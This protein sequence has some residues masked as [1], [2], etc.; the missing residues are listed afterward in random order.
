[1]NWSKRPYGIAV[2]KDQTIYIAVNEDNRIY[3]WKKNAI[4]SQVVAGQYDKTDG[5]DALDNPVNVIVDHQNDVLI[6]ADRGNSRVM[7]WPRSNGQC[8]EQIVSDIR[9]WGLAMGKNGELYVLDSETGVVGRWKIGEKDGTLVV[10]GNGSGDFL[11]QFYEPRHIFVDDNESVYVSDSGNH[12]VMKWMKDAREGVIVAGGH[13]EGDS[14]TQLSFPSG[15]F[16]DQLE[17]VYI[18]DS[19]NNRI[20]RWL[21]GSKEG[22]VVVGGND[23]GDQPDQL[24]DPVDLVFDEENNLYVSDHGNRRVQKFSVVGSK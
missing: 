15:I 4:T 24:D 12:R 18:A 3:Q 5:N 21:K 6:I 17:T 13:E 19:G 16:V 11:N 22:E 14:L 23:C 8:G 7:R 2:A 1:M 20:V 10:G 9:C